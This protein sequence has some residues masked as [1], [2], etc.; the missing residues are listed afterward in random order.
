MSNIRHRFSG[1]QAAC[2][3]AL[4]SMGAGWAARAEVIFQ[5]SPPHAP[6]A[7]PA[8]P[9]PTA[10]TP[11]GSTPVVVSTPE[12]AKL[13][14]VTALPQLAAGHSRWQS[15]MAAFAKADQEHL[16]A[17]DGVLFVG[18][19]TIRM[20]TNLQQDFRQ[21]PVI[22]NRGFGGST[23][24]DC[25]FFA[26]Q[27]VTQY[28]PRQVLVYAGDND[29]AEGRTPAQVLE[30]FAHFVR[31]VRTE[32]PT[33][34][35]S[36]ISIKPSPSRLA[37]LPKIRETNGLIADYVRANPDLRYIDIFNPMLSADG[38][39][40][41]E[42]FQADKLHMNDTGYQLWQGIIASHL[43]AAAGAS[44]QVAVRSRP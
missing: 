18:S 43:P 2:A 8:V 16:P 32:L 41:S 14:A 4:L 44:P 5:P 28:K 23:M 40:R 27:L 33:T 25:D 30:S 37:L 3:L 9:A 20:W 11:N 39:P 21:V 7:T 22:I 35:I 31:T 24:A 10:G 12:G 29:L 6:F 38:M 26:Q 19:S 36:Y 13:N 42:L 1:R 34:H 17:N 15:S